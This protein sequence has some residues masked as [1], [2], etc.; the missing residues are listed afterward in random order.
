MIAKRAR[1]EK[2][3]KG[4]GK[5]K[6]R[7]E[8]WLVEGRRTGTKSLLIMMAAVRNTTVTFTLAVTKQQFD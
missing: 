4:D 7:K 8:G 1:G 6:G 2:G 3:K 5:K